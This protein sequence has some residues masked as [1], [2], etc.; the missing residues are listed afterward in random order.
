MVRPICQTWPVARASARSAMTAGNAKLA[1]PPEWM[2]PPNAVGWFAVARNL[3]PYF[4]LLLIAPVLAAR[5]ALFPWL[6]APL[7]GL[8]AYRLTIVMHDCTHYALYRSRRTN[9]R[10]GRLLGAV[11]GIDFESFR[12]QHWRH[13]EVYG[14]P[15]DPQ[16]FHYDRLHAMT[17]LGLRRHLLR[18]LLGFNLIYTFRESV[19]YPRHWR[20]LI[21]SGE[22][23]LIV[24]V[25][26]ALLLIVTGAAKYWS[27]ALLPALSE[28][29]F[30]LFFSQL[31]GI[32]EHGMVDQAKRANY[33]R[34]HAPHFLDRLLL[35]DL[36]FNYHAEHH[37]YPGFP[38]C[39]LPAIQRALRSADVATGDSMFATLAALHADVE[40]ANVQA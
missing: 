6:L 37:R 39:H 30:G 5:S 20:R 9:D 26:A 11:T 19:L 29:T 16:G 8:F 15:G 12:S 34:S 7:F 10:V 4:L 1:L 22:A 32:A 23:F 24:A 18:P 31:R 17:P 2:T 33:V 36:N 13:H 21:R 40:A 3:L 28:V 14:Q 27:L 25:Q 35:Y 38:S